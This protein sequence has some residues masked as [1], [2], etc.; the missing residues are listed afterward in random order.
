MWGATPL[1]IPYKPHDVHKYKVT[2]RVFITSILHKTESI[3]AIKFIKNS[4]LYEKLIQH[5]VYSKGLIK[6]YILYLKH[7]CIQG[8]LT[9]I[10]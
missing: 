7:F 1:H 9:K 8:I 4:Q 10:K 3:A 6:A 2:F 5:K